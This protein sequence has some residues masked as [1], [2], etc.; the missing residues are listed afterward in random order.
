MVLER[1]ARADLLDRDGA[2]RIRFERIVSRA[3]L[4]PQ[5]VLHRAIARHQHGSEPARNA[6]QRERMRRS[7]LRVLGA[8][9]SALKRRD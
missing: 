7:F 4:L 8:P 9:P 2:G 6:E 1:K 3:H 5:P